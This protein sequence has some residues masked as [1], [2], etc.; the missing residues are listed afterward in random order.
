MNAD[1]ARQHDFLGEEF[2]T[3]LW[4]RLETDSGDFALGDGRSAAVALDDYLAFAPAE[5]DETEHTLR[6]GLPS[7]CAEARA[8]LRH[9]RRV[10]RM[11]LI[12]AI[13]DREWRLTVDGPSLN[14][15]GVRLPPDPEE[16]GSREEL[17]AERAAAFVEIRDVVEDL[18]AHFLRE[19]LRDDYQAT[20]GE[21][22]AQWRAAPA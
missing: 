8:A 12:V 2:L 5:Q 15:H 21:A 14:L 13:G 11:K 18:Y 16:A 9:G 3:W 10:R 6:K 17:A 7:R 1:E 19:R 22:Q 20:A 4:F